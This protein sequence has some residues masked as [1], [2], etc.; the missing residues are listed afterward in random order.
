MYPPKSIDFLFQVMLTELKLY[1]VKNTHLLNSVKIPILLRIF[2]T[3]NL[4]FLWIYIIFASD[5][6]KVRSKNI[7]QINNTS[8]GNI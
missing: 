1:C 8:Y 7:N 2:Y 4:E 5:L 6:H 3:N